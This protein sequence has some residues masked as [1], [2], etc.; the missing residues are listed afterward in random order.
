M[1]TYTLLLALIGDCYISIELGML[2]VQ[3]G[4][5]LEPAASSRWCGPQW[6]HGLLQQPSSDSDWRVWFREFGFVWGFIAAR[7]LQITALWKEKLR[8][9]PLPWI[10]RSHC[11]HIVR[12]GGY[13]AFNWC[14]VFSF[15]SKFRDPK[16]PFYPSSAGEKKGHDPHQKVYNRLFGTGFWLDLDNYFGN[17]S[18][19]L[20]E[21]LSQKCPHKPT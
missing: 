20:G 7:I 16:G 3:L 14:F 5:S 2:K 18:A 6:A 13:V 21:H 4:R 15:V 1:W 8:R 11:V 12:E 19:M 9:D 10:P 17:Q